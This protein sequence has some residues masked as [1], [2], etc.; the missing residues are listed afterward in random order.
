MAARKKI[1]TAWCQQKQCEGTKP[2]NW[3]GDPLPTCRMVEICEHE[4][5]KLLDKMFSD[6]G[7]PR[8]VQSNPEY[9][10]QS[11]TFWLPSWDARSDVAALE[12]GTGMDTQ[13]YASSPAAANVAAP[14]AR[15][16][17]RTPT[18]RK[19]RGQLE[20]EVLAICREWSQGVWEWEHCTPKVVSERIGKVNSAEP[21][22]V[23]AIG[24]IFD[25]W[26]KLGFARQAKKPV[27]F[28]EFVDSDGSDAALD[29]IKAE[30]KYR[31]KRAKAAQRRGVR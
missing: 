27:R 12:S 24:A 23:G 25:R 9:R 14:V 20:Y 17:T 4:C 3:K 19:A 28:L 7:V 10:P 29:R 15:P 6:A 18:G 1:I 31:T 22:S 2:R 5:H 16:A 11:T 21:P 30:L 8:V 26:E 13:P